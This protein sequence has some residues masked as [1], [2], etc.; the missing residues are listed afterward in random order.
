LER[1]LKNILPE[2]ESELFN[3]VIPFWQK[4]SMD[5]QHGG[6]YNCLD[7]KGQVFDTTK[8]MWL[9]GRQIWMFSKLCNTV[10]PEKEWLE[11]AVHGLDFMNRH[12]L[13]EN[14]RVYFSLNKHGGPVYLQR[15]IFTECFYTMAL[16]EY[17]K[18][19]HSEEIIGSSRQMFEKVWAFSLDPERIG[20]PK[21]AGEEPLQALAVPMILLNVMEEVYGPQ[22]FGQAADRARHCIDSIKMH[23]VGGVMH[24]HVLKGGGL[25]HSSQG[26]LVNPG[27]AIEAGWFLLH[28]ADL[29][30]DDALSEL[31]SAIVR[32]SFDLGWDQ[33]AGG[34]YYFLDAEERPLLQLE[35]NMKLWWPHCEALYAFLL[36]YAKTRDQRDLNTFFQIRKY[37]LNH[38]T[39]REFGEWYG[40]L[41]RDGSLS[42]SLKGGPY[43]GCFHVPRALLFCRNLLREIL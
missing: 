33:E 29:L 36:L 35:W 1:L 10:A 38:F 22:D 13:L 12:A 32:S 24:E 18:A 6:Y 2:L 14:G 5:R 23:F 11:T 43:K 28:W 20:R 31:A 4:Y 30:N 3:S 15:K 21:F 27:H 34:L 7:A 19:I 26:R 37:I 16:A 41:N 40:Y 9:H 42:S 17:G 39:D 25:H 8:Y